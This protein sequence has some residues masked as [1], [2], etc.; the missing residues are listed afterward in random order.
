MGLYG[1]ISNNK[2]IYIYGI[3]IYMFIWDDTKG[4]ISQ[5]ISDK[6]CKDEGCFWPDFGHRLFRQRQIQMVP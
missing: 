2:G 4:I 3:Y 6:H 5:F 1:I